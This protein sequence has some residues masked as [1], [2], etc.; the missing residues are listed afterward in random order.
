MY[1]YVCVY[2]FMYVCMYLLMYVYMFVCMYVW[3]VVWMYMCVSV[4]GCVFYVYRCVTCVCLGVRKRED[5]GV[6]GGIRKNV[7][8]HV[9]CYIFIIY[10]S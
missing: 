8:E 5:N 3:M 6:R 2:V 9:R 7:D 1:V 10:C 4:S